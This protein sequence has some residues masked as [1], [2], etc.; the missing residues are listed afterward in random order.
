MVRFLWPLQ[1]R[2]INLDVI[3]TQSTMTLLVDLPCYHLMSLVLRALKLFNLQKVYYHLMVYCH[4][5]GTSV[6][7]CAVNLGNGVAL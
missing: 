3:S 2:M 6:S 4:H 1:I 7:W 5:G